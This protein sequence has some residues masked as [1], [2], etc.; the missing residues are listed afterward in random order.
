LRKRRPAKG[1]STDSGDG[2]GGL[3][4][5]IGTDDVGAV[6][7]DEEVVGEDETQGLLSGEWSPEDLGERATSEKK[8]RRVRRSLTDRPTM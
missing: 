7:I 6:G 3:G 8:I 1:T 4:N 2:S 5:G